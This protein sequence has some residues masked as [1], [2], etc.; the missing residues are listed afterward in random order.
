ML[1]VDAGDKLLQIG[2]PSMEARLLKSIETVKIL[3]PRADRLE[4]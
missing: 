1:E 2:A 4:L 3:E